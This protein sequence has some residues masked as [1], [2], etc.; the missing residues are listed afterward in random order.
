[1]TPEQAHIAVPLLNTYAHGYLGLTAADVLV[2]AG[3]KDND[4][5]LIVATEPGVQGVSDFDGAKAIIDSVRP[6]S[7][8]EAYPKGDGE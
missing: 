2:A 8:S 6:S 1:M 7:A 3:K 4:W 5:M